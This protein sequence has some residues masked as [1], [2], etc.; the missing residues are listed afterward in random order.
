MMMVMMWLLVVMMCPQPLS[1]SH[2]FFRI[3]V[4]VMTMVTTPLHLRRRKG[5]KKGV[6]PFLLIFGDKEKGKCHKW[7]NPCDE[8][9]PK[10]HPAQGKA[11]LKQDGLCIGWCWCL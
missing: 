6:V 1:S 3:H 7:G 2:I 8:K 11:V 10:H 5:S 9:T 4:K